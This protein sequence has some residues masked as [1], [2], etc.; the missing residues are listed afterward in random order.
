MAKILII[1][2]V[3]GKIKELQYLFKNIKINDY[4]KIIFL[5]DYCDSFTAS[6]DD[7][8]NCLN[9]IIDLKKQNNHIVELLLGNHDIQYIFDYS[10]CRVSGFRPEIFLSLNQLFIEN[11]KL[12]KIVHVENN[13]LFSHAGLTNKWIKKV[14]N[15]NKKGLP[16]FIIERIN[17]L[18]EFEEG[19]ELLSEAGYVR[20]GYKYNAPSCLWAD[21]IELLKDKFNFGGFENVV[22]VVGHT[23]Q[24]GITFENNIY[25]TDTI[26]NSLSPLILE[27]ITYH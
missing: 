15:I 10:F 21:K 24:I 6:N 12:F 2:D 17:K 25:F 11:I 20:G 14:I 16:I 9:F 27:Q 19:I 8:L 4:Y 1:P 22:Q 5:G 7:I 3:H 26:G 23:P 13:F 18:L